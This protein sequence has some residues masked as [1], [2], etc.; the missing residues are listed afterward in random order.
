MTDIDPGKSISF[1]TERLKLMVQ[2]VGQKKNKKIRQAWIDRLREGA[3][4][5]KRLGGVGRDARPETKEEKKIR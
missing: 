5:E 1:S 4:I 2:Y 3:T